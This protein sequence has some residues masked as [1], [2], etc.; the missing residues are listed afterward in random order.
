MG[1]TSTVLLTQA[2]VLIRRAVDRQPYNPESN[3]FL[4]EILGYND[5]L[6]DMIAALTTAERKFDYLVNACSNVEGNSITIAALYHSLA[7]T[8]LTKELH[9][10]AIPLL[11]KAVSFHPSFAPALSDLVYAYYGNGKGDIASAR[12]MLVELE[13]KAPNHPSIKEMKLMLKQ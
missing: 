1:V 12:H 5:K 10:Y 9:G 4:G 2:E 8:Y 7:R 6:E 13:A 3:A 11:K